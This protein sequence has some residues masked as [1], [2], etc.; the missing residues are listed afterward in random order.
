[1][2]VRPFESSAVNPNLITSFAL[3]LTFY[4]NIK[5]MITE[6][7]DSYM[8]AT[9]QK[10]KKE[11]CD[12][13]IQMV[14]G[15]FLRFD[16][17]RS[18]WV[19]IDDETARTKVAQAFQYRQRRQIQKE[20]PD[21][22]SH[23]SPSKG[24]KRK[25]SVASFLPDQSSVA[26][27]HNMRIPQPLDVDN[28]AVTL[29][30]LRWVLGIQS[31]L[32]QQQSRQQQELQHQQLFHQSSLNPNVFPTDNVGYGD[33]YAIGI[34]AT[35]RSRENEHTQQVVQPINQMNDYMERMR[36]SAMSL[37]AASNNTSSTSSLLM[38]SRFQHQAHLMH[39]QEQCQIASSA[40]RVQG[41]LQPLQQHHDSHFL[42]RN[43]TDSSV[44]SAY[45]PNVGAAGPTMYSSQSMDA[46]LM[47]QSMHYQGNANPSIAN[48]NVDNFGNFVTLSEAAS[49]PNTSSFDSSLFILPSSAFTLEDNTTGNSNDSANSEAQRRIFFPVAEQI[50]YP[51]LQQQ[52][53]IDPLP[54][55]ENEIVQSCDK[56]MERMDHNNR[57]KP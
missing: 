20:A 51:T 40:H 17:D 41:Q 37:A 46:S 21:G 45:L 9:T 26:T 33:D 34:P 57:D 36:Q 3:F 6:H 28:S 10:A 1:M 55:D 11:T 38:Q 54:L 5:A 48:M 31:S 42:Q 2:P 44:M 49:V 27:Y 30:E 43:Q 19:E 32:P 15:R 53:L 13:I 24:R 56:V 14:R 8:N 23:D 25:L 35:M 18:C 47:R 4:C 39:D 7:C 29:D 12:R 16:I 50:V 52:L 22:I